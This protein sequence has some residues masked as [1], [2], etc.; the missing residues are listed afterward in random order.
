MLINVCRA[1]ATLSVT[2]AGAYR[3]RTDTAAILPVAVIIADA[4]KPGISY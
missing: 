2:L 4:I 1:R 3:A